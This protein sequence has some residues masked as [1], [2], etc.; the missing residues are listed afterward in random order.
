MVFLQDGVGSQIEKEI[1]EE[2]YCG[3]NYIVDMRNLGLEEKD[4]QCEIAD[5]NSII[6]IADLL[7]AD[8]EFSN[9][10]RRQT[11]IDQMLERYDDGFSR[12][13][14]IRKDEKVVA[15]YN[16]AGEVPGFAIINGLI[17]HP[18]YRHKGYASEIMNFACHILEKEN[19][20][21]RVSFVNKNNVASLSLHEKNGAYKI[22]TLAKFVKK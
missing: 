1:E 16:T 9:V 11:L 15:A 3:K 22:A 5:R 20:K 10:Y 14:I 17:V 18:Q 2:Y 21:S 8:S 6:D 13:F 19:I 4:Y 7:I 12:Y